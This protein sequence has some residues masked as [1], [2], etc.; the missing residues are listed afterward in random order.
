MP[1]DLCHTEVTVRSHLP[2]RG[3]TASSGLKWLQTS[4]RLVRDQLRELGRKGPEEG[5][6]RTER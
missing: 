5:R 3:R 1:L 4:T 6:A 2:A